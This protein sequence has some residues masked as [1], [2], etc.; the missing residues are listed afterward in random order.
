MKTEDLDDVLEIEKA[1]FTTPWSRNAFLNELRDNQFAHYIV[2][3]KDGTVVC[4]G[5]MWII[6]NEAHVTNIAVKPE[7]RGK[8]LGKIIMLELI[9]RAKLMGCDAMT[10]EVRPSNSEARA[11]YHKLGFRVKGIRRGYYVDTGEDAY[12]MWKE[13]L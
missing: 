13:N 7:Y 10:L 6:I 5:G 2:G 1:S 8:G 12:I 11:L 3:E 4:Y 9:E